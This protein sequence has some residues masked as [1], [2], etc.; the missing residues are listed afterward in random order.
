MRD[1][2]DE[3]LH[4][5][6]WSKY[7]NIGIFNSS[8]LQSLSIAD[9]SLM[10]TVTGPETLLWCLLQKRRASL[11]SRNWSGTVTW[12]QTLVQTDSAGFGVLVSTDTFTKH[13]I[14]QDYS[15]TRM[16]KDNNK[17]THYH[18]WTWTKY[19]HYAGHKI[20]DIL[21]SWLIWVTEILYQL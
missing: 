11:A 17:T 3:I 20:P 6:M 7:W 19:A 8:E 10:T 18:V 4:D 15:V 2:C 12:V 13:H 1:W 14:R 21:P 9:R 16:N 5:V